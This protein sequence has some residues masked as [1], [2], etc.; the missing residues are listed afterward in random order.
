MYVRSYSSQTHLLSRL[1]TSNLFYTSNVTFRDHHSMLSW[2]CVWFVTLFTTLQDDEKINCHP[3]LRFVFYARK[4][5]N[6]SSV[7]SFLPFEC[8]YHRCLDSPPAFF[9]KKIP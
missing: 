6:M 2:I 8:K 7:K 5:I 9:L 3:H 1:V 4:M